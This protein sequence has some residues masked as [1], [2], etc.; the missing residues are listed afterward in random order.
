MNV[1]LQF[2][3][4]FITSHYF[5]DQK[6]CVLHVETVIEITDKAPM[7]TYDLFFAQNYFI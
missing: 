5:D 4:F 7:I 1:S 2:R 6:Q 3:I